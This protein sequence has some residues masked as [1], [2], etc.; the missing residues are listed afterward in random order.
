M[1]G[2]LSAAII[3]L[4]GMVALAVGARAEQPANR[5]NVIHIMVDDLGWR[6]L[7][8]YGSETFQ[9]PHIDALAARGMRF[10]NAY[11]SSPLCSPTR[12]SVITGQTC[13]RLN[14][15]SPTGHL[16]QVVLD[17]Q[18]S[19]SGPPGMP[20][21]IPQT[22]SRV[23]MELTTIG[24]IF[25]QAGYHTALMGK[26]HLG[27]APYISENYGFDFVVGD[28]GVDGQN[29]GRQ[30]RESDG[31]TGASGPAGK[32]DRDLHLGQRREYVRPAGGREPDQ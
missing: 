21:T 15:T 16:P 31:R 19:D 11:S 14:F 30:R 27:H 3:A 20:M 29:A 1:R 8:V 22:A 13:G 10:S 25:Q 23:P 26:W 9:T 4:A 32:H 5:P 7:S 6:D 28:H 17:P 2:Q 18:E 12:A 24:Q